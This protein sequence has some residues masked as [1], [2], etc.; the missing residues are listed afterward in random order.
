VASIQTGHWFATPF[1]GL[2]TF[3]YGYVAS[4]V[5]SEQFARRRA[6]LAEGD[7]VVA[8]GPPESLAPPGV[9]ATEA[10]REELAA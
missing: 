8:S 5:A 1:A 3:G 9:P 2:F 7:E 4:L 10:E 6:A